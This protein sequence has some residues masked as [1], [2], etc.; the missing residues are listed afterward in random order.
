VEP[1]QTLDVP[2]LPNEVGERLDLAVLMLGGGDTT[3]FDTSGLEKAKVVAEV[4]EHGRADKIVVFKY[5]PKVRYRRKRGHRQGFSR[6]IIRDILTGD[7]PEAKP[8]PARRRSTRATATAPAEE[9][10]AESNAMAP[11]AAESPRRQPP[12]EEG[13]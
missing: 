11:A 10:V 2:S 12:S 9:T 5:K 8:A 7:E 3:L 4:V 1:G 6:L 13:E